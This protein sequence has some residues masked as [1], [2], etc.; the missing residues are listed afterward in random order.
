MTLY[1]AALQARAEIKIDLNMLEDMQ[2]PNLLTE[3][4]WQ[5]VLER[6]R[7]LEK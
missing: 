4:Q 7:K 6:K 1:E 2:R 3:E 5:S